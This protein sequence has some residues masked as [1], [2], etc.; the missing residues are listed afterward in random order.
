MTMRQLSEEEKNLCL[1]SIDRLSKEKEYQQYVFEHAE[2]MVKSGLYQN[3]LHQKRQY[4]VKKR[5]AANSMQD[6]D[7]QIITLKRQIE[8]GVEIKD[9]T[10]ED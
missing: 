1:K 3:Y 9:S 2:L 4:S 8:K 10:K 5:E 6:A 7:F